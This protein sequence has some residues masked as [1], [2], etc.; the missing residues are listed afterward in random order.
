[1]LARGSGS[2]LAGWRLIGWP[3]EGESVAHRTTTESPS[4]P[5]RLAAALRGRRDECLRRLLGLL[6]LGRHSGR[7]VR[8][9]FMISW[10]IVLA[11]LQKSTTI[12]KIVLVHQ[13]VWLHCWGWWG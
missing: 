11:W 2:W 8:P 12:M 7:A 6:W 4:S 10:W 5:R 9:R 3:D 1:L 13:P